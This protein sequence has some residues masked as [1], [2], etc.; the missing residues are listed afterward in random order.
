MGG[1]VGAD[2]PSPVLVVYTWSLSMTT[3]HCVANVGGNVDKNRQNAAEKSRSIH[4]KLDPSAHV[5]APSPA[6]SSGLQ[7]RVCELGVDAAW[8]E[9]ALPCS[10]N[11][12]ATLFRIDKRWYLYQRCRWCVGAFEVRRMYRPS[13]YEWPRTRA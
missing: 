3:V 12:V 4:R 10:I 2:R 8:A 7:G 13:L 1:W 11:T 6:A 9:G 5:L